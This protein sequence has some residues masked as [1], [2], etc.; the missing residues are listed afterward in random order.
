MYLLYCCFVFVLFHHRVLKDLQE[1]KE[2]P[3]DCVLLS[4]YQ[5]QAFYYNEIKRGLMGLGKYTIIEKYTSL[6]CKDTIVHYLPTCSPSEVVKLIKE[7]TVDKIETCTS[8]LEV[9]ILGYITLI[10]TSHSLLQKECDTFTSVKPSRFL[11]TKARAKLVLKEDN[12]TFDTK[13]HVFNVKGL[14]GTTRVVTLFPKQSCSCPSMGGCYHLIA[15]K[16]C[17][18]MHV[19]FNKEANVSLSQLR[20]NNRSRSDKKSGRKRPRPK[21]IDPEGSMIHMCDHVIIHMC[22]CVIMS[23]VTCTVEVPSNKVC[24]EVTVKTTCDDAISS[25]DDVLLPE[26]ND[27]RGFH[28]ITIQS[29]NVV[30]RKDSTPPPLLQEVKLEREYPSIHALPVQEAEAICS[31]RSSKPQGK[32]KLMCIAI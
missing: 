5:L 1:W 14:S 11:S 6:M 13:L 4:L 23:I 24:T 19:S 29:A 2:A 30:E 15:A 9:I 32:A 12:I 17:A 31:L 3:L 20:R 27:S 21:D 28:Q 10:F 16:L 7:G 25:D 22:D 8:L 26:G 18:G